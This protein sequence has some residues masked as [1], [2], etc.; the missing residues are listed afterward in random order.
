M[1]NA[2]RERLSVSSTA[3]LFFL[4]TYSTSG[5]EDG[6]LGGAFSFPLGMGRS[7]KMNRFKCNSKYLGLDQKNVRKISD[8][9]NEKPADKPTLT[10]LLKTAS[11]ETH[12][13]IFHSGFPVLPA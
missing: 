2:P 9:P 3:A 10:I 11:R 4:K 5:R 6:L 8:Y 12:G 7:T 1:Q 13:R